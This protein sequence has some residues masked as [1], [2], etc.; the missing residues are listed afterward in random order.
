MIQVLLF[1]PF[2]FM[3]G[4]ISPFYDDSVR[5]V[6]SGETVTWT[7][8][9]DI[10]HTITSGTIH[11]GPDGIFES[12]LV[13]P[14]DSYERRFYDVGVF[15]Y[16]CMAHPWEN[17]RVTVLGQITIE[18]EIEFEGDDDH[19]PSQLEIENAMLR[20]QVKDL[21]DQ[22]ADLKAILMEQLWVIYEWVIAR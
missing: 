10:A 22:V 11:N 19:Q 14:G 17:G 4:D 16:F 15:P 12:G 13:M 3:M 18:T 9:H 1:L 2:L 8:T 6:L 7:N 5:V 20:Q 21:Q